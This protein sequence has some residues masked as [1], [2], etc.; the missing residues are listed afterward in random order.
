MNLRGSL[1][2]Q[3]LG[4]QALRLGYPVQEWT[5]LVGL[6]VERAFRDAPRLGWKRWSLPGRSRKACACPR[7]SAADPARRIV[8]AP[9]TAV[10][11][12][13]GGRPDTATAVL[14]PF[15]A[16]PGRSCTAVGRRKGTEPST[17]IPTLSGSR[18]GGSSSAA[19]LAAPKAAD[20]PPGGQPGRPNGTVTQPGSRPGRS[21]SAALMAAPKA[22]VVAPIRIAT[23]TF[24]QRR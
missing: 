5:I 3:S 12:L 14:T 21:C 9:R 17:A 10:V 20:A 1:R 4:R 18:P 19:L 23:W 13:T 2:R 7:A 16:T 24:L 11:A 8:A 15:G 22:A 6:Q